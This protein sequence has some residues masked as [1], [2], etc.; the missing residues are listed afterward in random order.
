MSTAPV[1]PRLWVITGA[2]GTGKSELS[3]DLAGALADGGVPAEI[4]NADAMQLYR[5]MDIGT[6]KISESAQR[7]IPH[8]LFD[9]L[10]PREEATVARYQPEARRAVTETLDRG[11]HAILVGGSGLYISSVIYDFQFPPRDA[12]VRAALESELTTHGSE[13]LLERLRD[14]APDIAHAVDA[15]NPRRVVR[16]L[17]VVMLGGDAQV[18]MPETPVM[19]HAATQ[20]VT[21][22][23]ER[24]ELVRRLDRR[25]TRM[26]EDG[27]IEEVRSLIPEGIED[28][29]T[30]SRAIGYAQALAQVAGTCTE[31]QAIEETQRLTR[32]YARR[33]VSWCKRYVDADIVT[34]AEVADGSAI[35][36]LLSSHD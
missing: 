25:V 19:W 32:R 18:V 4:V 17:E 24:S 33:Q 5:G 20:V 10:S 16:A 30:A 9:L 11:H 7:G 15:R 3:L 13:A 1:A 12:Q 35:D 36:H 2:T 21:V 6:A 31:A 22:Q 27:L 29:P 26:W 28:G 14:L 23:E 8:H 34:S